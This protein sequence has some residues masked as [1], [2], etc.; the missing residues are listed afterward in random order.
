[1]DIN[2]IELNTS[3]KRPTN[4]ENAPNIDRNPPKI[5]GNQPINRGKPCKCILVLNLN[6]NN[7]LSTIFFWKKNVIFV[8]RKYTFSRHL[9]S[10]LKSK[11]TMKNVVK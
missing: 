5:D 8:I 9:M 3:G 11:R 10:L 1:M 6:K 4:R 2:T 7:Y